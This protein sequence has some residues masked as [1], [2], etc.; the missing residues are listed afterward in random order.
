MTGKQCP[1]WFAP[2]K[3]QSEAV[4][5]ARWAGFRA[6]VSGKMGSEFLIRV[7]DEELNVRKDAGIGSAVCAKLKKGEVYT[8]IETKLYGQVLWG[9]LKSGIGW[10]SLLP[11]YV[12]RI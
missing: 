8:V 10:V 6:L 4:A 9:R 11:R 12:E 7:K 5:N 3:Y 2:T 1:L